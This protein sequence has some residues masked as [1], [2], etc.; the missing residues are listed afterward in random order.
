MSKDFAQRILIMTT[1]ARMMEILAPLDQQLREQVC[2][3]VTLTVMHDGS[4]RAIVR[5]RV[6]KMEASFNPKAER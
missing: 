4:G 3:A 6:E 5:D 1:T 2:V